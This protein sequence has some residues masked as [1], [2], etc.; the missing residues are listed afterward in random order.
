MIGKKNF[1]VNFVGFVKIVTEKVARCLGTMKSCHKK[2]EITKR[3]FLVSDKNMEL[4]LYI[5]EKI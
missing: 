2:H 5:P 4:C 1:I 3:K